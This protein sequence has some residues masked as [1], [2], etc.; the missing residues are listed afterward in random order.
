MQEEHPAL[1]ALINDMLR[2]ESLPQGWVARFD[3]AK[4]RRYSRGICAPA[5]YSIIAAGMDMSCQHAL[6]KR[7]MAC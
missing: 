1:G 7:C 4:G 5:E 6:Q 3:E 2:P